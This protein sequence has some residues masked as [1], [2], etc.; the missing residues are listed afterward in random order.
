MPLNIVYVADE[1]VGSQSSRP[2][3]EAEAKR[4]KYALVLEA[5]RGGGRVVTSRKGWRAST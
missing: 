4:A 3:I 5:A 1:E 2:L